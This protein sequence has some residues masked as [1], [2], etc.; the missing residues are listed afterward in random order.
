MAQG[1]D[2]GWLRGE[3][4]DAVSREV[5]PFAKVQ[6]LCGPELWEGMTDFDGQFIIRVP[7]GPVVI[8]VDSEGYRIYRTTGTVERTSM[9][10]LNVAMERMKTLR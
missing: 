5:L 9:T 4:K 3:I 2:L 7:Y 6:V 8:T 1:T 10:F